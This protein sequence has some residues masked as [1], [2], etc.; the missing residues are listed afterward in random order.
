MANIKVSELNTALS[1]NSDDY[2]MIVQNNENKK[3]S[4]ANILKGNAITVLLSSNKTINQT[5]ES[6]KLGFTITGAKQGAGLTLDNNDII[7]GASISYI[8]VSAQV[9]WYN[10]L[11]IDTK[12][13]ITIYKNSSIVA[14]NLMYVNATNVH[15]VLGAIIIPVAEND[16]IS[17]TV[18]GAQ[19]DTISYYSSNTYLTVLGIN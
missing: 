10:P 14:N 4:K 1:F 9:Y 11:T 6:E 16:R 7:I 12:K 17:M 8:M 18:S 15:Q 5:G 13:T 3:I 2:T 19:G